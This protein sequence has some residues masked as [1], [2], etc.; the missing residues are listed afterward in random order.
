ML[1]EQHLIEQQQQQQH[2]DQDRQQQQQHPSRALT[3]LLADDSFRVAQLDDLCLHRT[4]SR[5]GLV[6][7]VGNVY[8]PQSFALGKGSGAH[9]IPN[10]L[11]RPIRPTSAPNLRPYRPSSAQN[12]RSR[13]NGSE[14]RSRAVRPCGMPRP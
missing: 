6:P 2:Q 3:G 11:R 12:L 1:L 5:P 9:V 10:K 13:R 14:V 4:D 7:D 8:P